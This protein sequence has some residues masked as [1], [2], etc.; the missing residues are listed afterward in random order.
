MPVPLSPYIVPVRSI[1]NSV[2]EGRHSAL[3]WLVFFVGIMAKKDHTPTKSY[4]TDDDREVWIE[5]FH[6]GKCVDPASP[7]GVELALA[8]NACTQATGHPTRDTNHPDIREAAMARALGIIIPHL[9]RTIYA[10]KGLRL[11]DCTIRMDD[12][13]KYLTPP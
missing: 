6:G 7:E 3:R 5:R 13:P 12:G 1:A 4:Y 8:Y 9:D 2:H 10:A 11:R